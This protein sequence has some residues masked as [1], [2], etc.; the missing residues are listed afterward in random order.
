MELLVPIL[1]KFGPTGLTIIMMAG[2]L[3]W[4]QRMNTRSEERHD[5]TQ[6]RF[7]TALDSQRKENHQALQE[8]VQ[9]FKGM[10]GNLRDELKESIEELASKVDAFR[11]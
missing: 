9:E 3:L 1:E 8:V 11:K 10:H 2:G 4:L 7:L 5:R 6:D